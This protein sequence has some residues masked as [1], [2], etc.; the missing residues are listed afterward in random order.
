MTTEGMH[1]AQ[2]N[3]T[4]LVAQSLAGNHEAFRHIVERYQTLIC[5]V[6]Y[7]ATGSVSKSEDL[8]QETFVTAWKDLRELREPAKLRSWL[9]SILR[10]RISKQFR[11]EGRE[12]SGATEPLTAA[13]SSEAPEAPPS[14]QAITNEET[15]ILWRSLERIPEMYREPLVLFYREQQSVEAVATQLELSEDAVKQRLSRGRKMLQE[16]VAAFVEGALARTNPGQAFTSAVLAALPISLAASAKAASTATAL[17]K[18]GAVATGTTIGT[19]FG[20]LL[21]PA[22]GIICGYLG[23]RIGLKKACT[24]EERALIFRYGR[25]TLAAVAVFLVSLLS[26]EF[27]AARFWKEHLV[28]LIVSGLSITFVYGAFIFV[29][30]WR[31][32][33]AFIKMREDGRQLRPEAYRAESLPLVWEYRSRAKLFGIPLVHCKGGK[34]PGQK[35]KPAVG[36]IAFGEVAYGI[37]YASGG[38]AVGTI[39]IGGASIGILSFGGFGLGLLA[40][41]GMAIGGVAVGGAAIGLIASGGFAVG[42]HAALGGAALAREFAL[43]G[44]AV[45]HHANDDM[46]RD[47]FTRYRW[48]DI[49]KG[50][51][52]NAFWLAC[53]APMALQMAAWHWWQRKMRKHSLQS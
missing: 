3:D 49:S 11:K 26:F 14:A 46:A 16:E 24:P 36:W 52:R 39:S 13:E 38:F 5:S 51:P 40:F 53:F 21:G 10:F 17:A 29:S 25:I 20:V 23:I 7:S 34:L 32:N 33:R 12:P 1:A 41:G 18:A 30:A 44:G 35:M 43:G 22:L 15:A 37:L 47:F 45:A 42:W 48:L 9:C 6:A 27:F 4:E 2:Q 31:F 50:G 19:V 8:A 28:M